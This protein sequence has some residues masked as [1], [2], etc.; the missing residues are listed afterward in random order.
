MGEYVFVV[1]GGEVDAESIETFRA[2]RK[3]SF[4]L[5]FF[6]LFQIWKLSLR[7]GN[8]ESK[9]TDLVK[10]RTGISITFAAF[11]SRVLSPMP[12]MANRF[13]SLSCADFSELAWLP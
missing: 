6:L 8:D 13:P 5:S 10:G 4:F 7:E 12:G 11:H 2:R 9:L 3:T 1:G